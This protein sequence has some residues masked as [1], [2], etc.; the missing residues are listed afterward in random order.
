MSKILMIDDDLMLLDMLQ[1]Y[2]EESGH[3]VLTTSKP[4]QAM[5]LF[6]DTKPDLV[7]ID[8]VMPG[9][10]G[11][12]LLRQ[13]K[14]IDSAVKSMILSGLDSDE[15]REKAKELGAN[16]YFVKPIQIDDFRKVLLKLIA[17]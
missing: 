7:I 8:V 1:E 9:I 10:D 13:F 4:E 3:L 17:D 14:E 6:R 12:E 15:L 2:V 16:Q 11:L 5:K